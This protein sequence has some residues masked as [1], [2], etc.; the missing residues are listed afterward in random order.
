MT[1]LRIP[2]A[3]RRISVDALLQNSKTTGKNRCTRAWV[4]ENKLLTCCFADHAHVEMFGDILPQ[5][6]QECWQLSQVYLAND[7]KELG[8]DRRN[9]WPT[10]AGSL[11]M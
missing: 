6:E 4:S 7:I 5:K 1:S 9:D 3:G 8:R 10:T 11:Q 2:R